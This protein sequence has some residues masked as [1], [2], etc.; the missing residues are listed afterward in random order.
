MEITKNKF[1]Y[2]VLGFLILIDLLIIL[3]V[4]IVY[5]RE[6]ITSSYIFII[7]GLLL[8]TILNIKTSKSWEKIIYTVGLSIF[9][10][11]ILGLLT[12]LILPIFG[13][14][15]P[16]TLLPVLITFNIF[17]LI[18]CLVVYLKKENI[19]YDVVLRK[20]S[21]LDRLMLII[22]T[23]FPFLSVIGAFILNNNGTNFLTLILLG[24]IALYMLIL[25]ILYKRTD[26]SIYPYIIFMI[27]TSL[28]LMYSMRS[29]HISGYDINYE[30]KVFQ[31]TKETGIWSMSH[32]PENAYNAC[33]S[34]TILPT[35]ISLFTKIND[36]Y[37]FKL[38]FP[39]IFALTPVSMYLLLKK[40]TEGIIAFFAC[41]FFVSQ[42]WFIEQMP[43]LARQE[44]ALLFFVIILL[45]IFNGAISLLKKTILF[46]IFCFSMVVSHYTTTYIFAS[47]L[48]GAFMLV[49]LYKQII[50]PL[51]KK[52]LKKSKPSDKVKKDK[53]KYYIRATYI[54]ILIILIIFWMG[55]LTR[56]ADNTLGIFKS[57]ILQT[58]Q[59]FNKNSLSEMINQVSVKIK[60]TGIPVTTMSLQKMINDTA[61][62]YKS[63]NIDT[64][65]ANITSNYKIRL[66]PRE[67]LVP[68]ISNNNMTNTGI[69][70]YKFLVFCFN[71]LFIPIGF[72][73]L[74]YGFFSK[75]IHIDLELI[76][77]MI[78]FLAILAILILVPYGTFEYNLSRAYLQSLILL[79][80]P[81]IMGGILIFSFIPKLNKQ[82]VGVLLILF[83]LVYSGFIFQLFGGG[84][85]FMYLNNYGND[86][87]MFYTHQSEVASA[88]WLSNNIEDNYVLYADENSNLRLTAFGELKKARF[89]I[90]PATMDK[91]AYVYL[92]TSNF[93]GKK[94]LGHFEIKK[95]VLSQVSYT[96]PLQFLEDNKNLVYNDGGSAI[97]R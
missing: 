88:K 18:A 41:I 75:K 49:I 80:L 1:L 93:V 22:P 73:Y 78:I 97:Y 20:Y 7:P 46:T 31:V 32:F 62:E 95:Y 42:I 47:I 24:S 36:E 64:F 34:I 84:S 26:E 57:T 16:L 17:I 3:N 96:Y 51:L 61:S 10:I 6:I 11:L 4:K 87:D 58:G 21:N 60:G 45:V 27:A 89:G 19:G 91:K 82:I 77:I 55:V 23:I 2:L 13:V 74:I 29:W 52:M 81:A 33:L 59:S 37:I 44:I 54:I 70:L 94:A 12:S 9:S 85:A 79:S 65:N 43:T 83:F 39:I 50:S 68:V 30:F 63:Y 48:S 66:A 90:F 53:Y 67:N 71:F 56:T 92:S 40:Y 5:I 76:S 69:D 14:K 38:V 25:I 28:L 8:N 86:Y 72:L 35:I 15:K